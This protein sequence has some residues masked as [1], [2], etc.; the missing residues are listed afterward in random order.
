M[1]VG[2]EKV[3]L[4]QNA[5]NYKSSLIISTYVYEMGMLGGDYSFSTAVGLFNT[6]INV[7]LIVL[8][9]T[10]SKRVLKESLW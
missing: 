2:F 7:T 8:A 9:N 6:V 10:F 1:G 5:L 4:L 3:Y